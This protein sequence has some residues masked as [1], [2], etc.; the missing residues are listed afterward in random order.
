MKIIKAV[1]LHVLQTILIEKEEFTVIEIND[2]SVIVES[3][4][5]G[6]K[7][8]LPRD[9]EL[10]IG[11]PSKTIRKTCQSGHTWGL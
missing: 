6:K 9:Q 5:D 7:I 1:D 10:T 4:F 8:E 2:K 3:K 11:N